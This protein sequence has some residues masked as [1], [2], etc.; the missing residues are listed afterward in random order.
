MNIVFI[1]FIIYLILVFIVGIL[2]FKHSKTI[3]DYFIAGRKL[4]PWVV[5]FSERASGESAWLLIGV[6]GLAFASG[7]LGIWPAIGCT[8]GIIFSWIFIARRLRE[9]TEVFDAITLPDYFE[10]KHNDSTKILRIISASVIIFFFTIYVAAQFLAAGKVLNAAFDIPPIWGMI[11]GAGVILFYTVM[12]GFFAVAWTDLIQGIIMVFTL[13]IL[14]IVGIIYIG[15]FSQIAE[16]ISFVNPQLLSVTGVKTGLPLILSIVGSLG[17]GLGYMGQPHLLSRFMASRSKKELKKGMFIASVWALLAFWGATFIGIM[18]IA[19]LR[20]SLSAGV[21]SEAILKGDWFMNL[22]IFG[23][24]IDDPEKLMPMMAKFLTLPLIAGIM[25]SG[26]IAAM[27]STADSQLLS[28]TS[29]VA[30]DI[31]HRIY[32]KNATQK[33]LVRIS[34]IATVIIGLFAFLIALTTRQLVYHMVLFAWG[35]LGAVFGPAI[36]FS[37]WWKKA[38][39]QGISAGMITALIIVIVTNLIPLFK[40]T[41]V[42]LVFGF[43][44]SI[45]TIIIVSLKTYKESKAE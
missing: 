43:F 12:G 23:S 34:R 45:I 30:E 20:D 9:E 26:A 31:Y 37:L 36:F 21:S 1:G 35:G 24:Q 28:S 41:H 38:T 11:I 4:N 18:G 27:M 6:P 15:G 40:G 10:A 22:E 42:D 7:F 44:F 2:T 16:N 17:I 14:P 3:S 8:F 39:R 32:K 29:A 13:I 19:I 33:Q 5:A 25:I